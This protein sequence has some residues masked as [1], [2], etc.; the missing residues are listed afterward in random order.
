MASL[1]VRLSTLGN[2]VFCMGANGKVFH[3]QHSES[4]SQLTEE[5]SKE[6]GADKLTRSTKKWSKHY[7]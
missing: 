1:T 5:D 6:A 2:T 3:L 7:C 4:E